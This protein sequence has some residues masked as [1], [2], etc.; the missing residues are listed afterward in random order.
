MMSQSW[1]WVVEND[2]FGSSTWKDLLIIDP[3]T[4]SMIIYVLRALPDLSP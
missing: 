3:P 1:F 2:T 4:F